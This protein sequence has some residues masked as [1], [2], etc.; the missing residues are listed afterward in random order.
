[1]T[2]TKE[3]ERQMS[4]IFSPTSIAVIGASQKLGSIGNMV[5][6]N[7]VDSK[8]SGLLFPINPTADSICGVK[9]Y[10]SITDVPLDE[11]DMAV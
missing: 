4:K 3:K 9:A 6:Q 11:I 2:D 1:M 10:K 7:L 8:F 5:V